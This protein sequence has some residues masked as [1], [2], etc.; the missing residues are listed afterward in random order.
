M[1]VVLLILLPLAVIPLATRYYL[2]LAQH[3]APRLV[4]L[5]IPLAIT[6]CA[7]WVA[8]PWIVLAAAAWLL[9]Y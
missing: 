4:P 8:L 3:V 9:S 7:F 2:W 6:I 1:I 5:P